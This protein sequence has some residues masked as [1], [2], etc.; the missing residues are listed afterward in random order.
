L[1]ACTT[2]AGSLSVDEVL[3]I[4]RNLE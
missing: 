4:A 2:V 1:R 3:S